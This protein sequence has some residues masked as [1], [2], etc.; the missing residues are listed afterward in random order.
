M[1]E[2]LIA[3]ALHATKAEKVTLRV[4]RDN[5]AAFSIY[6]KL[7]FV[8]VESESNSEVLAMESKANSALQRPAQKT[9]KADEFKHWATKGV[10]L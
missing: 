1:C 5:Q 4:Y 2:F 10:L 9:A 8:S 7:G 6:S 3:E